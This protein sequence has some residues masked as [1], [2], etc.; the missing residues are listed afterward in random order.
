MLF[1]Y[2]IPFLDSIFKNVIFVQIKRD[3]VTNIASVLDARKSQLG[4]IESWYSFKIKE[5]S[6]IKNLDPVTQV[7]YQVGYIDRSVS[8]GLEKVDNAR[9]LVVQYED[10]CEAPDVIFKALLEKMEIAS[11]PYSGPSSFK[12]TRTNT[13]STCYNAINDAISNF[14]HRFHG[15]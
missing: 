5:Y 10:F 12:L 13:A 9:K 8:E 2:N 4:N 11:E 15:V 14:K 3:L 1:N 7:A 6:T